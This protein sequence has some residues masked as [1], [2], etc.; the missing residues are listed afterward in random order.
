[1]LAEPLFYFKKSLQCPWSELFKFILG[2]YT[3]PVI[4]LINQGKL[5]SVHL[6]SATFDILIDKQLSYFVLKQGTTR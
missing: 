6:Y 2:L 5:F 4:V 1:M 3:K